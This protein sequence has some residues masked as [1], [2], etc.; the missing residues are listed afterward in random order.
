MSGNLVRLPGT[1]RLMRHLEERRDDALQDWS[2]TQALMVLTGCYLCAA[3]V[4]L[5]MAWLAL[6]YSPTGA[7]EGGLLRASVM[8]AILGT[9]AVAFFDRIPSWAFQ[10]LVALGTVLVT[11]MIDY[12]EAHTSPYA[13]FYIWLALYALFFFS[14]AQAVVQVLFI[15]VAYAAVLVGDVASGGQDAL[16]AIGEAAPRWIMTVGT[17]VVAV[18]LVG[19]LKER[20][21]R[22]IDRFADAAREDPVTGLRN[23]RGF[24]ETFD[25]E[26]ERARRG[27]RSLTLLLGDLDHFKRVNDRLGHPRGD[28]ALR[29]AAEILRATNRR[30]DLVARVGGEEFAVLLPD[31]D[32]RGAHI[33]AERMRHAIREG[34]ADDPVPLTISFGVAGFPQHGETTD[35]LME[36]AD[37]ALYTAK[38]I[39]RDCSVI[40][41]PGSADS[42]PGHAR[43]R[44]ARREARLMSLVTLAESLDSHEHSSGVGRH[45]REIARELGYPE[46][47]L[48]RL[49][50]AA[51]LHD[52]GKVGIP[53]SIV[54]KPG[55][56]TVVEWAV[57]R[58][59]PEIGASMIEGAAQ[60]D[61]ADWVRYH[62]ERPDGTGYPRG[63]A[64]DDIPLES[65][66]VAVADAYETMTHDRVYRPAIGHEAA[67]KE[68]REGAGT[69]FD[70]EVVDAFLRVLKVSRLG[71]PA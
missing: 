70:A 63:L 12:S 69:Q 52:V 50:L 66:I 65:R 17:L 8:A 53:S 57:M 42:V 21:D 24:D 28:D 22:L 40:Y 58:K 32:E 59:H 41:A 27:S 64:G 68:L 49:V 1:K 18:A 30:I 26:V 15:A 61:L 23:R 67:C 3:G 10:A 6:P 54:M 45:T 62:H 35:D 29:R 48:E 36:S 4:L 33:A 47:R 13:F 44:R 11:V 5:T 39:G 46:D 37:Q 7:N 56:L 38:E 20:L 25:L 34:F 55:P 31:S 51:V 71:A 14:R 60:D 2:S 19:M 9:V 43:R 16:V